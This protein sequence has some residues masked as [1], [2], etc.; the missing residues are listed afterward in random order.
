MNGWNLTASYLFLH[1]KHLIWKY[2]QLLQVL[3][4]LGLSE[5]G[6]C[7]LA[8][9]WLRRTLMVTWSLFLPPRTQRAG[10]RR[11]YHDDGISDEEIDGRR[12][13]DLEEKVTSQRFGSDRVA[14]MEG[15]GR[16]AGRCSLWWTVFF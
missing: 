9:H 8:S 16:L 3:N 6:G 10:T 12:M 15:K 4:H 7:A 14:R 5:K 13:F 1:M 2:V 11:R